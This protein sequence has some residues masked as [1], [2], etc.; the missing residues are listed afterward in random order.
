MAPTKKKT[1]LRTIDVSTFFFFDFVQNCSTNTERPVRFKSVC[2][3]GFQ[4]LEYALN[5]TN[6]QETKNLVPVSTRHPLIISWVFC[7]QLLNQQIPKNLGH[8]DEVGRN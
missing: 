6:G 2:F 5:T 1:V 7:K 8:D 4:V 3:L